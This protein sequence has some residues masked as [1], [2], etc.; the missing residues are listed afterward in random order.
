MISKT[1]YPKRLK[2]SGS[3]LG[4]H[5]D[6]HARDDGNEIGKRTTKEMIEKIIDEV[7]PD[8]LQCDC[9]GHPGITSYPTEVGNRA[10]LIAGDPLRIWRE[11]TARRG[12]SL[13]MH[14]SG[15]WD[16]EAI[17][18]HPDWARIDEKGEIDKNN[19]SVFG[20]YVDELLIPQLKE[21]SDKYGI[22]GVWIDGDC[23]A[24]CQDYGKNVIKLFKEKTGINE[25]PKKPEDPYFYE[26]TEFCRVG[27]RNYVKHYVDEIHKH[28]PNFEVASNWSFT[29]FM[30]EPVGI[31]VDFI[32]GDYT[33]QDSVNSARFEGRCMANKG[34]PWDL[35]AWSFSSKW[36]EEVYSTKSVNQ[37]KQ[38][39][40][41]VLSLGGGFQAYFTQKRDGS[42]NLWQMKLMS[43]VA[44]F[45][46]ERQSLCH[47]AEAVPQV[48][49]FYSAASFYRNN[50]RIFGGWNGGLRPMRGILQNLLETQNSVEVLAEFQLTGRMREYPLIVVPEWD[51]IEESF[52]QELLTYAKQGGK[53]LII[54]PKA[55]KLFKEELGVEFVGDIEENTGRWIEYN[56]WLGG[57][58]TSSQKVQLKEGTQ[59]FGRMYSENDNVE[60][61]DPAASIADYSKGKIA[62]VY[63]DLGIKYLEGATST[64]RD[65]IGGIVRELFPEPMV[66]VSGS[67]NV[68]VVVNNINETLAV[69]LV[70]T[71]GPHANNN[72]YVF[73]EIPAV[74]PLN[75]TIQTKT[76]PKKV[77]LEPEGIDL[78][79]LYSKGK[80]MIT[81]PKLEIHSIITIK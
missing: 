68:D 29:S 3:F 5:F 71:A 44:K 60:P 75:I 80:V 64:A 18:H 25:V 32:S 1:T 22:D 12:V 76:K 36:G 67:H 23:W 53:L 17:K 40:A 35:M 13:Y 27:F 59:E 11:V 66:K 46:R 70:N 62:A 7:K 6:F 58:K 31:D 16:T 78:E 43:E 28:N 51:Y 57:L 41:V 38:E 2:R 74:G 81:L 42:V 30:P 45:C 34:K 69:N 19:T 47:R 61:Y 79:Y 15:V 77:R 72:V 50:P 52:R 54:G 33:L 21:L 20:A 24:T 56:G 49:L 8:Y 26:F 48:A 63:L 37:L 55:A 73:D 14:Y 39:A 4:V 10:E 65:F 9:K